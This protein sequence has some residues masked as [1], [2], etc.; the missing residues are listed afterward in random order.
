M[1]YKSP[2]IDIIKYR[3]GADGRTYILQSS[4]DILQKQNNGILNPG[5]VKFSSFYRDGESTQTHDYNGIFVI[6]E[7]ADDVTWNVMYESKI[8]ESY[9]V[10]DLY[11]L[12]TS[13]NGTLLTLQSG[14]PI[15]VSRN[16]SGIRCVLYTPDKS[17]IIDTKTIS[18]FKDASALSQEEIFNILTNNGEVKGIYKEG[19]QL[20]I[21]F[22]YARGGELALGGANNGNGVLQILDESGNVVGY[23][24]NKGAEFVSGKVGG[25]NITTRGLEYESREVII[26]PDMLGTHVQFAN[27]NTKVYGDLIQTQYLTAI[28]SFVCY[29]T[30]NRAVATHDYNTVLQYCYEMAS[31]MFGDIGEGVISEDGYCYIDLDPI[32]IE[33]VNM[34][35]KYYVFLQKEGEGDVYVKE[36]TP[37]YFVV[38]G[39]PGLRFSWE[40]KAKQIDYDSD[41]LAVLGGA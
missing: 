35:V 6:E 14:E 36:K 33:T 38:S 23:A 17:A 20:Y 3:N 2:I 40:I 34:N 32:F 30:K 24:S 15:G 37:Q 13:K 7:T 26:S 19:N 28:E 5:F 9:V 31:P 25:W 12:L 18:V 11:T 1:Q 22:T 21:S 27:G 16:I 4:S 41:R 29:G 10:H 39:T 8:P